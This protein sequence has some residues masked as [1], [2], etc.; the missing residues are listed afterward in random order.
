MPQDPRS[1]SEDQCRWN[2]TQY[3]SALRDIDEELQIVLRYPFVVG[4]LVI[5]KML[6][7]LE[8]LAPISGKHF[9]LV[10]VPRDLI[11]TL[12]QPIPHQ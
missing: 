7:E 1:G 3:P 6:K 11:S 2:C 5:D 9:T 12:P 10:L 8:R 4:V